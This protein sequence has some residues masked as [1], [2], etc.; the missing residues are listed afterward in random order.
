MS[1]ARFYV[2]DGG[3]D[4]DGEIGSASRY[5]R[6][7]DL[8]SH[9]AWPCPWICDCATLAT[10]VARCGPSSARLAL[11][12]IAPARKPWPPCCRLE[13]KRGGSRYQNL[14][15]DEERTRATGNGSRQ[16]AAIGWGGWSNPQD[17]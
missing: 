16:L 5:S 10:G 3:I 15:P 7:V 12:R 17:V 4:N 14:S 2:E 13:G 1:H 8:E 11:P 9:R 6:P